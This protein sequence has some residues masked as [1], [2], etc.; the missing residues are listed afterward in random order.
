VFRDEEEKEDTHKTKIKNVLGKNRAQGLLLHSPAF[1]TLR[2][3]LQLFSKALDGRTFIYL[4]LLPLLW[5]TTHN[6]NDNLHIKLKI[7]IT[8]T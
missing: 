5:A 3:L 1:F 7:T 2:F 6:T 8:E 4:A